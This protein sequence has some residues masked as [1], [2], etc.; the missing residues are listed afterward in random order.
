MFPEKNIQERSNAVFRLRAR[1]L[2]QS[3]FSLLGQQLQVEAENQFKMD[4]KLEKVVFMF[5]AV[6]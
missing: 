1:T 2:F 4:G 6:Q 5:R 3:I